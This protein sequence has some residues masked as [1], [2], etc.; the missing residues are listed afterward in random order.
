MQKSHS[1]TCL[2]GFKGQQFTQDVTDKTV[3]MR[4]TCSRGG[5]L[6]SKIYSVHFSSA[7][8]YTR[9]RESSSSLWLFESHVWLIEKQRL[10]YY[11]NS[12]ANFSIS[13]GRQE[14]ASVPTWPWA[15]LNSTSCPHQDH[16]RQE[17]KCGSCEM[18]M[19]DGRLAGYC[20]YQFAIYSTDPLI[21]LLTQV[22]RSFILYW[23]LLMFCFYLLLRHSRPISIW[24]Q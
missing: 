5:L 19:D 23:I 15:R 7:R 6:S 10:W 17:W 2:E 9:G 11:Q 21:K 14:W 12:G 16:D 24:L 13:Q 4:D 3:Q 20:S 18:T 1:S 8:Q 22:K